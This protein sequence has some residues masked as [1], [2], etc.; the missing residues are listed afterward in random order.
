MTSGTKIY[1]ARTKKGITTDTFAKAVGLPKEKIVEIETK[2]A[3]IPDEKLP[4]FANLLGLTPSGIYGHTSEIEWYDAEK[5]PPKIEDRYLCYSETFG[6]IISK[7]AKCLEAI[8]KYDFQG[9]KRSGFY[10]YE[11]DVGYI[12]DEGITHWAYLPAVPMKNRN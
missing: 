5:D 6:I 1:I 8:D 11:G 7:F 2:N 4:L 10:H 3:K 12:K 9:E